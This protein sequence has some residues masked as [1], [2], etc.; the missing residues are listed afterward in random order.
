MNKWVRSTGGMMLTGEHRSTG[1]AASPSLTWSTESKTQTG[2]GLNPGLRGD[3]TPPNRLS[4]RT[5]AASV[6]TKQFRREFICSGLTQSRLQVA[7]GLTLA[8]NSFGM[9]RELLLA[10][11]CIDMLWTK[12]TFAATRVCLHIFALLWTNQMHR[13]KHLSTNV[14]CDWNQIAVLCSRR[15]S[16]SCVKHKEVFSWEAE[17]VSVRTEHDHITSILNTL[18]A[19][20]PGARIQAGVRYFC[21]LQ[22]VRTNSGVYPASNWRG[23]GIHSRG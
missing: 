19:E 9:L 11:V 12:W 21:L 14:D 18:R 6:Y 8:G 3:R 23:T 17:G 10:S 2:L 15:S 13:P 22:N 20:L 1:T 5:A 16:R 7:C 4:H